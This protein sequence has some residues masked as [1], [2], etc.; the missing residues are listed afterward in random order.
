MSEECRLNRYDQ[1]C[2]KSSCRYR[3]HIHAGK[4]MIVHVAGSS[5]KREDCSFRISLCVTVWELWLVT[6]RWN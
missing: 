1:C 4:N 5:K 6:G 3:H 2:V